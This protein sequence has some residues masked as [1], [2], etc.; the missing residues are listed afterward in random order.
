MPKSQAGISGDSIAK[1]VPMRIRSSLKRRYFASLL[2]SGFDV[3][4]PRPAKDFEAPAAEIFDDDDSSGSGIEVA[5]EVAAT[6]E[7]AATMK[8]AATMEAAATMKAAATME[9]AAARAESHERSK[10]VSLGAL[11]GD[12]VE[13]D[14]PGGRVSSM[15]FPKGAKPGEI[16]TTRVGN[17]TVKGEKAVAVGK[18][19][20]GEVGF[21]AVGEGLSKAIGDDNSDGGQSGAHQGG[22]HPAGGD[23]V[24][25]KF[26]DER[27][28]GESPMH[29]AAVD[30]ESCHRESACSDAI[31][32]EEHKGRQG[33]VV[34]SARAG[35][36]RALERR[37]ALWGRPAWGRKPGGDDD[38][39]RQPVKRALQMLADL[40]TLAPMEATLSRI[41]GKYSIG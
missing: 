12:E 36:G 22:G 4:D 34:G 11:P 32:T 7:A 18:I 33:V 19:P 28:D 9:E 6:M 15:A 25:K 29:E 37:M 41:R 35:H 10:W 17:G 1:Q 23:R 3:N 2:V 38:A 16:V 40:Y 31:V 14:L 13:F 5:M 21:S 8:A 39:G 27:A 30:V 20:R 26:G 24:S